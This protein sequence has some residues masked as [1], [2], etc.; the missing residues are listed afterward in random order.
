MPAMGGTLLTQRLH[1]INPQARVILMTGYPLGETGG[2]R[3][4]AGVVAWLQKPLSLDRLAEVVEGA[5]D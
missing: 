2:K 4:D 1:E 3:A 5:L